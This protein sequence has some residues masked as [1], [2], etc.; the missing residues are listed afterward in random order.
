LPDLIV[1]PILDLH[2]Y[3][4]ENSKKKIDIEGVSD[5]FNG[6]KRNQAVYDKIFEFFK[7][8]PVDEYHLPQMNQFL[9]RS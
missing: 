9:C 1:L 2:L 3:K 5:G 7:S 6:Q 8:S 4:I